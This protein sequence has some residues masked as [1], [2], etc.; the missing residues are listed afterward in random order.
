MN[1]FDELAASRRAWNDEILKPWCETATRGELV[2]AENEW[3]NVA[4]RVDANATLWSWAWGRFPDLV[5]DGLAGVNET[6]E[7]S[8]RL[9]DGRTL[10][11]FPDNRETHS[12]K[13]AFVPNDGDVTSISIDDVVEVRRM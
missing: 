3:H 6:C 10:Q 11:G 1:T 2:K 9:T 7:V 8:I 13:L 4:G 12:G 5:H